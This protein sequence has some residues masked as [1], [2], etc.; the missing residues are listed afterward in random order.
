MTDLEMG[1][2]VIGLGVIGAR[3]VA[4]LANPETA[5]RLAGVY[6]VDSSLVE[7]VANE[8]GV[9]GY[10]SVGALLAAD[11][12]EAV[13]I[14][15]P[16]GL[17]RELALQALTA[18]KHV[19]LEKPLDVTVDASDEI[20]RAAKEAP[21][22]F[23]VVSQRRF[24][25]ANQY[26]KHL[27]DSG[28]LGT[29]TSAAIEVPLW[30]SQEYYDSAGWRGTWAMDGGGALMN[31]GV[32]LVDL[33]L[34]LLGEVDEVYAHTGLLAHERIEV[35]D[36]VTFTAR[37]RTGAFLTFLATT[38]AQGPPPI[39]VSIM[40]DKGTVVTVD[41]EV[42]YLG[43]EWGTQDLSD[44]PRSDPD[45]E[46]AIELMLRAQLE[47]FVRAAQSDREPMVTVEQAR[48]A[49]ALIEAVYESGRSGR[50]VR[51]RPLPIEP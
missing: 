6:D 30:R 19:L 10:D 8:N 20:L 7:T 51:P 5:G 40:G 27:V 24:A 33:A 13:I 9:Q 35:E 32:H 47:D 45:P 15:V 41:E 11:E 34:W 50:P 31:Q 4:R 48:A 43:N 16:S 46:V 36:T 17:H 28:E 39:R 18:E 23:S 26:L 44:V 25:Q 22:T 29:I 21:T 12:I 3:H 42:T 49:V 1:V 2:G 37:L 38:A 14:A